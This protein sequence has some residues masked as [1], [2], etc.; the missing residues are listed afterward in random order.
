MLRTIEDVLGTPHLNLNTA[1]Q[2]PM[3]DAFDIE[4]DGSWTYN[5]VASTILKT[6]TLARTDI[7]PGKVRYASGPNLKSTRSAAYWEKHT[8]GFDFSDADR[9]PAGLMNKAL[10]DGLRAG[11]PYPK[12]FADLPRN[13]GEVGDDD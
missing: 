12:Q 13:A 1:Y 4:S 2:R 10:W 8:K 6:T 9:V 11:Q 3:T 5:A 7:A